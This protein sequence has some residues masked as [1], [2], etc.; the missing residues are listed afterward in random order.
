MKIN[1]AYRVLTLASAAGFLFTAARTLTP[2]MTEVH[3]TPLGYQVARLLGGALIPAFLLY[4]N[5]QT[6]RLRRSLIPPELSAFSPWYYKLT[7]V[8]VWLALTFQFVLPAM[9]VLVG[10]ASF[11]GSAAAALFLGNASVAGLW[12]QAPT[13]FFMELQCAHH[14]RKPNNAPLATCEDARG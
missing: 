6:L 1:S 12:L 8:A 14:S 11:G 2:G 13:V 7:T 10:Y 9:G 3:S 4:R 5:F